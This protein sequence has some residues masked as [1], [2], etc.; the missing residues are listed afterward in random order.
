MHRKGKY[1]MTIREI[2]EK[3]ELLC[4][5]EFAM[6]GDNVG[7]LIG[8]ENKDVKKILLCCDVDE[9][10]A[11]EAINVNADLIISHH[12]VM[13][14]PIQKITMDNPQSRAIAM[15]IENKI[16]LYT[17]HTNLDVADGGLNDYMASLLGLNDTH[18]IDAVGEFRGKECGYGRF[19]TLKEK[20]TLKDILEK[21]KTALSLDGCRYAGN[22]DDEI[23]TVAINTGGGA[24]IIDLCF[25]L[26]AS[27]I[28]T[29]DIKYNAFRDC[30]ERGID[31]IDIP[32]FDTEQ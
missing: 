4:P 2:A 32:H 29:G 7:L 18:V 9:F 10:V 15:L 3:I 1:K 28:I 13:F 21:C 19:C 22:L 31:V 27:L 17:A 5:K 14:H 23:S 30:Y 12:P 16:S 8:D 20:T 24:G 11:K 25:D 6:D 26:S